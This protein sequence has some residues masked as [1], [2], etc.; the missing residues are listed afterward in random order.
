MIA[1]DFELMKKHYN[2]VPV[3]QVR[4]RLPEIPWQGKC[5]GYVWVRPNGD[6]YDGEWMMNPRRSI[7]NGKFV[8]HGEGNGQ[9]NCLLQHIVAGISHLISR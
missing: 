9:R 6:I 4:Q 1:V 8:F 2:L 7:S 5:R 3:Q